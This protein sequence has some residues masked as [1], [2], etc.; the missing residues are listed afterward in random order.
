[1]QISICHLFLIARAAPYDYFK[2]E[3]YRLSIVS[4]W[5]RI[6]STMPILPVHESQSQG[7]HNHRIPSLATY[8]HASSSV[9]EAGVVPI[10]G[11][12]VV[13]R[14]K[15]RV[16]PPPVHH[17]NREAFGI[18]SVDKKKNVHIN[19]IDD[20]AEAIRLAQGPLRY[21]QGPQ[22]LRA[23]RGLDTTNVAPFP[24]PGFHRAVEYRLGSRG[25]ALAIAP[26]SSSLSMTER[27]APPPPPTFY[28]SHKSFSTATGSIVHPPQTTARGSSESL[29]NRELNTR[30]HIATS[31]VGGITSTTAAV[32]LGEGVGRP[33]HA[34]KIEDQ[35]SSR[36]FETIRPS[37]GWGNKSESVNNHGHTLGAAQVESLSSNT[38]RGV[39]F[40]SKAGVE[41]DYQAQYRG[42]GIRS[43]LPHQEFDG[44][45][46]RGGVRRSGVTSSSS[47]AFVTTSAAFHSGQQT[48]GPAKHPLLI[49]KRTFGGPNSNPSYNPHA[50]TSLW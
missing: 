46:G 38:P 12:G 30:S 2:K 26:S 7:Q 48:G 1:M 49:D 35:N 37:S 5:I 13:I 11:R 43:V 10:G 14:G 17:P 31:E 20:S 15:G 8:S 44:G 29:P 41:K 21:D 28:D 24:R 22:Q 50:K 40:S 27:S 33:G 19:H 18:L 4:F 6:I 3:V 36:V 39:K 16:A 34:R 45:Q 42:D 25:A 23:Q 9:A 47:D 32:F